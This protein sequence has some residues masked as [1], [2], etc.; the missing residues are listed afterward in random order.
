MSYYVFLIKIEDIVEKKAKTKPR[1]PGSG[2]LFLCHFCYQKITEIQ[3]KLF[4]SY[5][6][7]EN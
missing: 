7:E 2:Y 4:I 1:N 5:K 3:D 6:R